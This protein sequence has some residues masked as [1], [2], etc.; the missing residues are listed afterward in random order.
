[1]IQFS[2]AVFLLFQILSIFQISKILLHNPSSFQNHNPTKEISSGLLWILAVAKTR[3]PTTKMGA[4]MIGME[5]RGE[6]AEG[7]WDEG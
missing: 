2:F 4:E 6:G 5:R 3:V 1:M 7:T